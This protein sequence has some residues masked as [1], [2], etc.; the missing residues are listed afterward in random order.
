M[1]S[2]SACREAAPASSPGAQRAE[3]VEGVVDGPAR[4]SPGAARRHRTQRRMR[5][6]AATGRRARCQHGGQARK[7]GSAA[8]P[9]RRYSAD[10]GPVRS[11]PEE[12]QQP[13]V[14]RRIRPRPGAGAANRTPRS[15]GST[16]RWA[17][18]S[19]PAARSSGIGVPAAGG[20]ADVPAVH[21]DLQ[22]GGGDQQSAGAGR[23][24]RPRRAPAA[25]PRS[26][27]R[28]ART[29]S[30]AGPSTRSAPAAP[31]ARRRT[32]AGRLGERVERV[33]HVARAGRPSVQPAHG[34]GP[35][36]QVRRRRRRARPGCRPGPARAARRRRRASA[37]VTGPRRRSG[38]RSAGSRA[39]S[40]NVANRT[41]SKNAP[42]C[43]TRSPSRSSTCRWNGSKSPSRVRM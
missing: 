28:A 27:R 21:G 10:G 40:P 2:R 26:R 5:P 24:R 11:R 31:G 12:G 30:A 20:L 42:T 3:L 38:A 39:G 41:V 22:G 8:C 33:V 36:E 1:A 25:G 43:R 4:A 19:R 16:T 35:V 34:V 29:P 32:A 9:D 15:A 6:G 18:G 17:T 37:S 14:V 23:G 13:D 7:P